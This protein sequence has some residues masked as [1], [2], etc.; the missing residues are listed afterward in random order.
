MDY[1]VPDVGD[2]APDFTLEGPSGV[3]VSL[4]D[5]R[6]DS[7]AVLFFYPRDFTTG[8]QNQLVAAGEAI[9]QFQAA[10]TM[11][12]GINFGDADS[13][14]RFRTSM[15]LPFELLVDEGMKVAGSYGV[16]NPDPD[17]PGEF[18]DSVN[19]TVL[20]VGKNGRI[21][22]RRAGAPPVEEILEAITSANDD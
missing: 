19:R 11:V 8:C 1:T 4:K 3:T 9:E 22:Y 2:D 12:F 6:G 18:L 21:L 20:V 5:L 16:L 13:H 14:L 17:K 7:R 15:N 10:E